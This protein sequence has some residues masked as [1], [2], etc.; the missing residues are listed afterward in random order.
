MNKCDHKKNIASAG[1]G[2]SLI[3]RM[4][5]L[6]YL[7]LFFFITS[8]FSNNDPAGLLDSYLLAD[9]SPTCILAV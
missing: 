2:I 4:F 9:N 3:S 5:S 8:H 7:T 6:S 1:W